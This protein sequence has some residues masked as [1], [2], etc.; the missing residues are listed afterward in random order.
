MSLKSFTFEG[1]E[2]KVTF[3][4]TD[5]EISEGVVCD[6]YVFDGDSEKDLGI[7]KIQPG[8]KSPLQKVLKGTRTVE[9]FVSGRGE[10]TVIKPNG[11]RFQRGC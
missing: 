7:I 11:N 8:C 3:V 1:V 6:V 10:L 9:G 5:T 4:E 2:Q